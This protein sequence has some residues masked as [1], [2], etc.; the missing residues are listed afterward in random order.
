MKLAFFAIVSLLSFTSSVTAVVDVAAMTS[1]FE[2][3][4]KGSNSQNTYT[5][6]K[7]RIIR[8][9]TRTKTT[10]E[11]FT[12]PTKMPEPPESEHYFHDGTTDEELS[13]AQSVFPKES[14]TYTLFERCKQ[15]LKRLKKDEGKL[16][17][18]LIKLESK[19][20]DAETELKDELE[21]IEKRIKSETGRGLRTHVLEGVKKRVEAQL[22]DLN[23]DRSADED[24]YRRAS[25]RLQNVW[26]RIENVKQGLDDIMYVASQTADSEEEVN[27]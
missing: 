1:K 16:K 20:R 6:S 14:K 27:A 13:E 5:G 26:G 23:K 2:G 25:N 12:L 22:E 9:R 19:L 21:K 18:E 3:M 17:A 8:Q 4:S 24:M 7:P 10:T 15:E 11:S